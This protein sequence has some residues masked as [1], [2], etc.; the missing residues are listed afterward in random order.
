LTGVSNTAGR[1]F[2]LAYNGSKQFIGVTDNSTPA[3]SIAYGYDGAGNLASF[4]DP[5]GNTTTYTYRQPGGTAPAN[6]LSQI[7]Y[8][9][10]ATPFVSNAYDT[11]GRVAAQTNGN[12]ATWNYFFAGYRSE[13]DDACGTRHVLYYNPRIKPV[14]DIPEYGG[15]GLVTAT[16]YDGLDRLA[17]ATLPEGG[18]ANLAIQTIVARRRC[19]GANGGVTIDKAQPDDIATRIGGRSTRFVRHGL[20]ARRQVV[21]VD[22]GVGGRA[23]PRIAVLGTC[24]GLVVQAVRGSRWRSRIW[25]RQ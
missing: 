14:F 1:S 11:L 2:T 4:T 5:L 6:L 15:L 21:I 19:D 23:A 9:S 20:G 7:F 8:P 12:G 10:F 17:V 24:P 3:R 25:R 18:F 22:L 13:E 16:V